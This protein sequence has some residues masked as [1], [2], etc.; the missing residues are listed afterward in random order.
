MTSSPTSPIER[1]PVLV[2]GL[3]LGAER[4]RLQLPAVDGQG[5]HAADERRADVGAA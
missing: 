1:V 4:A 2:E 3:D 5:G